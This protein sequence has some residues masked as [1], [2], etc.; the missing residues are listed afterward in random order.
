M[1]VFDAVGLLLARVLVVV[2]A[3]YLTRTIT[4]S[5]FETLMRSCP[6]SLVRMVAQIPY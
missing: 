1:T 5:S 2:T 3:S 6:P 4:R